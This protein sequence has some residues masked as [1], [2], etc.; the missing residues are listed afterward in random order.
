MH[1]CIKI[2][3]TKNICTFKIHLSHPMII[4]MT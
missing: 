4:K 3:A 1:T 2:D